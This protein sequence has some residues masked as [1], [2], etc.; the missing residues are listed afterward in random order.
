MNLLL[1]FFFSASLAVLPDCRF[2]CDDPTCSAICGAVCDPPNCTSTDPQ[3]IVS[4]TTRCNETAIDT[5]S[6][7]ECVTR[8]DPCTIGSIS[9]AALNCGWICEKGETCAQPRCELVCEMPAYP[10]QSLISSGGRVGMSLGLLVM[11]LIVL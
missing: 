3:C 2:A 7:P 5:N 1:I 8:C 10:F 11:L 4:C 6:P 9:C